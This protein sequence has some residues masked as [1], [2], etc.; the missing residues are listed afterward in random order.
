MLACSLTYLALT[1][2]FLTAHTPPCG[3][4]RALTSPVDFMPQCIYAQGA[5]RC[6]CSRRPTGPRGTRGPRG[7]SGSEVAGND[8][9]RCHS[10]PLTFGACSRDRSV[11]S[12][13]CVP[14][15]SGLA[16]LSSVCRTMFGVGL[17]SCMPFGAAITY[18]TGHRCPLCPLPR[19]RLPA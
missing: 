18:S 5:D 11:S 7:R 17:F 1:S 15:V 10:Y 14:H 8:M 16:G 6:F 12:S 3:A 19:C 13:G 2:L 9:P 4:H